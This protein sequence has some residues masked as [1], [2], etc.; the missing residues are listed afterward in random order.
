MLQKNP[1]NKINSWGKLSNSSWLIY[2]EAS[3]NHISRKESKIEF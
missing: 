1:N 2:E 3:Y